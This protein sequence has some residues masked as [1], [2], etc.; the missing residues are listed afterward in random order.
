MQGAKQTD[1]VLGVAEK[2]MDETVILRRWFHAHPE[3]SL[4]EYSTSDRIKQ[5]LDRLGIPYRSAG[6]TGI[7]GIIEGSAPASGNRQIVGLRADIDALEIQEQ[8]DVEY[9][10]L[11]RGLMHACGHDSHIASL[12]RQGYWLKKKLI[13]KAL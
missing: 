13:L 11:N 6:E 1:G 2:Y 5:E 3:P 10:S 4:K 7:V 12:R 8:N 9:R